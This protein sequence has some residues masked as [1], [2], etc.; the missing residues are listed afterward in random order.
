MTKSEMFDIVND[1]DGDGLVVTDN[2]LLVAAINNMEELETD[3][4]WQNTV[5]ETI[6]DIDDY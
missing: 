1:L 3:S 6:E 5:E 2:S 4:Y